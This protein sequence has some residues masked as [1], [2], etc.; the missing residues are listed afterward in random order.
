MSDDSHGTAQV[1]TNYHRLPAFMKKAGIKEI[2]Y[3]DRKAPTLNDGRFGA[4]F[5]SISIEDLAQ[6]PF[7]A[8][9]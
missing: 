7:W 5:S 1:G 3:A 6:H 2:W 9:T 8:T 4:G